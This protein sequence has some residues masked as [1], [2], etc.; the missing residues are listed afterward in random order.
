MKKGFYLSGVALS[1]VGNVRKR[2]E[3]AFAECPNEQLFVL[4][5]G[6][7]GHRGGDV[8]SRA[9]VHGFCAIVKDALE[10]HVAPPSPESACRIVSVAIEEIN[11]IIYRMG[12]QDHLLKGMGTTL[13]ALLGL[14]DYVVYAHVGDSRIYLYSD[15]SLEQLTEDHSLLQ[16]LVGMGQI[17]SEEVASSPYKNVLTRAVGT[18]PAVDPSVKYLNLKGGE[19]FLICSDGLTEHVSPEEIAILLGSKKTQEEV[20]STLVQTAISRGGH[21]NITLLLLKVTPAPSDG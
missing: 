18:E 20:A 9:C 16:E 4:A 14:G 19:R 8:A 17:S 10:H 3:D 5:D 6:M 1:D 2:N 21:D 15:G 11:R 13:C 12:Q 7:G